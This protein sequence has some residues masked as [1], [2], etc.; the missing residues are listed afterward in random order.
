MIKFEDVLNIWEEENGVELFTKK[1]REDI[2]NLNTIV[3][4]TN[5]TGLRLESL[6]T[7]VRVLIVE[8]LKH[9]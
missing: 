9:D 8:A 4:L 3:E 2:N 6:K 5:S 1:Q 7:I